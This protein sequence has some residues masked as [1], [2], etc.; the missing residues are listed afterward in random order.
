[1]HSLG[2]ETCTRFAL[3]I[4]N[5]LCGSGGNCLTFGF[6]RFG[7]VEVGP[8]LF[9]WFPGRVPN[10]AFMVA[11]GI[12]SLSCMPGGDPDYTNLEHLA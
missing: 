1:M 9:A 10:H 2:S 8:C 6:Y 5:C 4:G 12:V 11:T 7:L 3:V